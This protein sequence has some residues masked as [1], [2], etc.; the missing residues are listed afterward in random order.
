MGCAWINEIRKSFSVFGFGTVA[1]VR[2][3]LYSSVNKINETL[4]NITITKQSASQRCAH[5]A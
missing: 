4:P 1:D 3:C 2:A 5:K